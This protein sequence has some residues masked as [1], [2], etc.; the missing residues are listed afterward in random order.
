MKWLTSLPDVDFHGE[1][2]KVRIPMLHAVLVEKYPDQFLA[3]RTVA[4]GERLVLD[5]RPQYL[6]IH[7]DC[8]LQWTNKNICKHIVF[9]L[10]SSQN[11]SGH[12]PNTSYR[13]TQQFL[14][15]GVLFACL[16]TCHEAVFRL[17]M[18]AED[19]PEL[20]QMVSIEFTLSILPVNN[21][22]IINSKNRNIAFLQM[23]TFFWLLKRT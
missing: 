23:L 1:K 11:T 16:D 3:R 20:S 19:C 10:R 12:V 6:C 21:F 4:Y 18:V 2:E 17:L 14:W 9:S 13:I 15:G 22:L 7:L 5:V 8:C